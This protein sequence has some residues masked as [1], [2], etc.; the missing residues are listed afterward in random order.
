MDQSGWRVVFSVFR[1]RCTPRLA[2][3]ALAITTFAGLFALGAASRQAAASITG[4]ASLKLTGAGRG[5]LKEGSGG[6]CTTARGEGVDLI[7]LE[8]SVD[9]FK[10]AA[11]WTM[12]L[13][14]Q[15]TK[16]GTFKVSSSG[17]P[18]G[19]LDPIGKHATVFQSQNA[20]LNSSAGTYTVKGVKGTLDVTFGTGKKAI[21]VKGS[22]NCGA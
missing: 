1:P 16:G 12:V 4:S 2:V 14:S 17:S 6:L 10:D 22:W 13:A 15:S 20:I 21:T 3:A 9:G 8:G 18:G 7:G 5:A 19:Q 11:T